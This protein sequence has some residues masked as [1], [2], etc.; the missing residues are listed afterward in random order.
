MQHTVLPF[1]TVA[2]IF[3]R[4]PSRRTVLIGGGTESTAER[5]DVGRS[6]IAP[7]LQAMNVKKLD[8]LVVTHADADHC[9]GLLAVLRE[10]PVGIVLDGAVHSD[11]IEAAEYL[12]LRRALALRKVQVVAARG[13]QNLNLGAGAMLRVLAPLL[14]DFQG[15]KSDNNNAAVLKLEYGQTSA[16]LT[17]DI[18]REAEERIVRCVENLKCTILKVAHHGSK[19][20]TQEL[21]L[22]VARPQAAII[23]CGRYNRFGHPNGGVLR[24][25]AMHKIAA[26]RTDVNGAIEVSCDGKSCWIPTMR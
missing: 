26:F 10:V 11:N 24:R 23:S 25:L 17:A 22:R 9:N 7:F 12:Q 2:C 19:T 6:V 8:A 13:G 4:S 3:I 5:G 15:E 14:P 20:S 21:F 18:E 16:L 1:L